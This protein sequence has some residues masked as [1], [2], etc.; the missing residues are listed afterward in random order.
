MKNVTDTILTQYAGSPKLRALIETFNETMDFSDFTEEFLTT[1]WDVS[2]AQGY[3]LDVWGRIVGV[4]RF[5]NVEENP[6]T[7][8]FDEAYVSASASSPKPFNEAPFYNGVA[9]TSTVELADDAYRTLIMAKAMSNITDCSIP[10]INRLLRYLFSGRGD[11]FVAING[12]MSIRYVF[13]FELTPVEEAIMLNS[14][15]VTKPA[16]VSVD[17]MSLDF[18]NTFGFNEQNLQPFN[19]G[20]LFPD[21]GIRNAN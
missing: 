13:S 9:A 12:V 11:V 10:N 21:S 19:S 16:G 17:L 4:S 14:N 18:N 20:T 8:G 1:L 2:T 5:L 15:A 3:G 6:I 7:F